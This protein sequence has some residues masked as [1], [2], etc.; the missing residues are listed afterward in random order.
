M[1]IKAA[2]FGIL[3]HMPPRTISGWELFELAHKETG[4]KT[5]PSTLLQYAREY[6]ELSGASF[7]PLDPARSIYLYRPGI[8][9]SGAIRD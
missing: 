9:I 3:D 8:E 7:K 4:Q 5:Y 1:T 6:A 2:V